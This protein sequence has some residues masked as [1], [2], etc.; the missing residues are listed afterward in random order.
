MRPLN[1]LILGKASSKGHFLMLNKSLWFSSEIIS[2]FPSDCDNDEMP[3]IC[4]VH[5]RT[6]SVRGIWMLELILIS[7]HSLRNSSKDVSCY[8]QV[9]L[10]GMTPAWYRESLAPKIS[11]MHRDG[12][13]HSRNRKIYSHWPRAIHRFLGQLILLWFDSL[14]W[15]CVTS[16]VSLLFSY[17]Y[18]F[19]VSSTAFSWGISCKSYI[20]K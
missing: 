19:S 5:L 10:G 18:L 6:S 1:N 17:L 8:N 2:F 9:E 16:P 12:H 13:S 14:W 7:K 20:Q 15:F 4:F 3:W 11:V